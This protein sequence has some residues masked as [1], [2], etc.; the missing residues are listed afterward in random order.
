MRS[1]TNGFQR[2]LTSYED[3]NNSLLVHRLD[4]QFMEIGF[5]CVDRHSD[6]W[7]CRSFRADPYCRLYYVTKGSSELFF[8]SGHFNLSEG[9]VYLIPAHIPFEYELHG[10]LGHYW[11]HLCSSLL[12]NLPW[13]R[14]PRH[15]KVDDPIE[16]ERVMEEFISLSKQQDGVKPLME[17]DIIARRLLTPMLDEMSLSGHSYNI[18]ACDMFSQVLDYVEKHLEDEISMPELAT[19]AKMNRNDFSRVFNSTFQ[20]TPKQYLCRR[21]IDKAKILLLRSH[22]TVKQIAAMVGY[23]D[24]FYFY[25]IFK[26]Y[27]GVTPKDYRE[28]KSLFI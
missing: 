24:E 11:I 17:M 1:A 8:T 5:A 7:N 12:E 9:N 13:F 10:A 23:T 26:K 3:T 18:Q 25:R 21:R 2:N 22:F 6:L 27:S 28:R 20:I 15:Y 14:S 19:I 16:V 4:L